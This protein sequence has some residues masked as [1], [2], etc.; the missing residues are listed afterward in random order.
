GAEPEGSVVTVNFSPS[1]AFFEFVVDHRY[2]RPF[3]T[4]RSSDLPA[5]PVIARFVKLATPVPIV[6][7]VRVP[8]KVPPPVAIAAVTTTPAWFT[9]LP[10]ASRTRSAGRRVGTTP[11]CA[12]AEGWVVRA[13]CVAAPAVTVIAV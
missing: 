1:P 11:R 7:A 3:P 4:R 2:L 6:V 10:L 8:S 13:N 5:V 12:V 9:G